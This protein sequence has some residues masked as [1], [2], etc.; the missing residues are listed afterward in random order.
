MYLLGCIAPCL[1]A[2]ACT[3]ILRDAAKRHMARQHLMDRPLLQG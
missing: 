3:T 1:K 2:P